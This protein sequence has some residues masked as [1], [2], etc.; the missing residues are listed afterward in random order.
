MHKENP[1]TAA[2]PPSLE[3]VTGKAKD[4]L[5]NMSKEGVKVHVVG[6]VKDGKLEISQNSLSELSTKFPNAK[7]AFVAVNAPFDPVRHQ[8]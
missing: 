6:Q 4:H 2:T 5:A 7:F 8:M 1:G 3:G